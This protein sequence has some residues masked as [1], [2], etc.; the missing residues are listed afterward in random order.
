VLVDGSENSDSEF[1]MMGLGIL[2]SLA[3]D[4]KELISPVVP[5]GV[6]SKMLFRIENDGYDSI[7]LNKWKVEELPSH[8]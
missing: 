5:L 7:N 6:E 1:K 2:P 8:V 3:F 4:R